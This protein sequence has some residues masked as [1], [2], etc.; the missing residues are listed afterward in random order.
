M[1][2]LKRS[3]PLVVFFFTALLLGYIWLTE[4]AHKKEMLKGAITT[5]MEVARSRITEA[6]R[7]RLQILKATALHLERHLSEGVDIEDVF[8]SVADP[9]HK[10][11]PEF[12]A[13]NW[14]EKDGTIQIISP[15]RGNE[16]AKGKN[17]N[18]H[19]SD[20][21]RAAFREA[22]ETGEYSFTGVIDLFQGGKG[23]A[24]YFPVRKDGQ[25]IGYLNGVFRIIPILRDAIR[26]VEHGGIRI[27]GEKGE[28]VIGRE[29]ESAYLISSDIK[30]KNLILH[31]EVWPDEKMLKV[32]MGGQSYLSLLLFLLISLALSFAVYE[33][34][35]RYIRLKDKEYELEESELRFRTLVE[36]SLGGVYLIQDGIFRY[37]N[38]RF[39]EIFGYSSDEIIDKMGPRDLTH[40]DDWPTVSENLKKRFTGEVES[41]HYR[42]RCIR[43]DGQEIH[44]EVYGTRINWRGRPAVIGMLIDLTDRV[45]LEKQLLRAQKL[46]SVGLL[47][48]GIAHDF[49]NILTAISGYATMLET[50]LKEPEL[51]RR[52]DQIQKATE[53]AANLTRGL[54]AFS[55]RQVI[56]PE[57]LYMRE[58]LSDFEPILRR[59]LPENISL[60]VTAR[61]NAPV[62]ADRGQIEQVIMNLVT[63]ARDAMPDGGAL[64]IETADTLITTE[65]I[66]HHPW[67]DREGEYVMLS[68]TDTGVGMDRETQEHIFEPF[69]STK[70]MGRGTGLGLAMVFGIVKQ[71]EGFIH[72]YSEKGQGTTFRIYLPVTDQTP[73]K[74]KMKMKDTHFKGSGTILIAE[75]DETVRDVAVTVLKDAGFTVLEARD[76]REAEALIREDPERPDLLLLDVVMPG[77]G[78]RNIY[79][80]ALSLNYT[81]KVLFMSGYAE[82]GLHVNFVLAQGMDFISKPFTPS[83]LLKKVKEVLGA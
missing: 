77:K 40:P 10:S 33:L 34:Q 70:E 8:Q 9:I 69:F 49:N 83:D 32:Y 43:K 11:L 45:E 5:S 44:V 15:E 59:V 23:V 52:A 78:G 81:G 41:M 67:V 46:E 76:G 50:E 2:L 65:Y 39:C 71:H 73:G 16:Q 42:F 20:T 17:V 82:N 35:R 31:I 66:R 79:D 14:I 24:S 61:E 7:F 62:M 47:A 53:R 56:K 19:P 29:P 72:V 18:K 63:N 6:F 4:R 13:I 3:L 38:P 27:S 74:R 12:R 22:E 57:P 30:L 36:H 75:D 1:V 48:G 54:L 37:V 26:G 28:T 64:S 60:T 80:L 21:V 55:R 51:K 68:V 25:I 58:L